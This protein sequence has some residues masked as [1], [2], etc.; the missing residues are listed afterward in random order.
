MSFEELR[1][2]TFS[3]Q[4][5]E[6]AAAYGQVVADVYTLVSSLVLEELPND[7]HMDDAVRRIGIAWNRYKSV[8]DGVRGDS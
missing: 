2:R 1:A 5:R 6:L 4:D 3:I 8:R 7:T